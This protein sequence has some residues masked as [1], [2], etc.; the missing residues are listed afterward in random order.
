MSITIW[1]ANILLVFSKHCKCFAPWEII[2]IELSGGINDIQSH[3]RNCHYSQLLCH[4]YL[5]FNKL[6]QVS[7]KKI[8]KMKPKALFF[9]KQQKIHDIALRPTALHAH[10]DAPG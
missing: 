3:N 1:K 9:I 6:L 10:R 5:N 2:H 8:N 4:Y 7:T